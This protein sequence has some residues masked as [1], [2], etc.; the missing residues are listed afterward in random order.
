[1]IHLGFPPGNP[2]K[3]LSDLGEKVTFSPNVT[4]VVSYLHPS[5]AT[6]YPRG[7]TSDHFGR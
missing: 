3:R 5:E 1:M 6:N 4:F 7:D 2:G